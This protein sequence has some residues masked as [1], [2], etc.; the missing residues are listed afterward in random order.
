MANVNN[1]NVYIG[2][3]KYRSEWSELPPFK[4]L[5]EVKLVNDKIIV[6]TDIASM[7]LRKYEHSVLQPLCS[8]NQ[9]F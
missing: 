8:I 3:S 5:V 2:T 7:I 9:H 1:T 4:F 6:S